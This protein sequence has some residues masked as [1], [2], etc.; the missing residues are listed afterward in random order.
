MALWYRQA[1]AAQ[2]QSTDR[3]DKDEILF[4]IEKI[5]IRADRFPRYSGFV[6]FLIC[7]HR[8]SVSEN[9]SRRQ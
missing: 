6:H 3:R 4:P 2:V 7:T 1:T 9:N 5:H 8:R